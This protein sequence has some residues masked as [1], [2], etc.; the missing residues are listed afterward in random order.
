M[1]GDG[2]VGAVLMAGHDADLAVLADRVGLL[3]G[4]SLV[5]WGPPD[6]LEGPLPPGIDA[7]LGV[8]LGGKLSEGGWILPR[9]PLDP[10]SLG[11]RIAKDLSP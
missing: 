3:S 5:A 9:G 6:L 1:V 7:P 10:V 4:G 8:W 11:Q 2:E